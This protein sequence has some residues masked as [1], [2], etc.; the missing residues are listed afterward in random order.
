[1]AEGIRLT[2]PN[3]AMDETFRMKVEDELSVLLC[4]IRDNRLRL[5]RKWQ[6]FYRIFNLNLDEFSYAG[7]SK[8]Y[9]PALRQAGETVVTSMV[10][11]MFPTSDW[12]R[13]QQSPDIDPENFEDIL[14]SLLMH[15]FT[16]NMSLKEDAIPG[17]TQLVMYGSSPCK[18]AW[19]V[20]EQMMKVAE[21]EM[22]NG[23]PIKVIKDKMVHLYYGPVV[24]WIDL[25]NFYAW[26]E[27]ANNIG[28]AEIVF[29]DME[30]TTGHIKDMQRQFMDP[31]NPKLGPVYV[32]EDDMLISASDVGKS[33]RNFEARRQRLLRMG[34]T[35]DP[36]DRW[37][38][39]AVDRRNLTEVY[40]LKD[41]G[42]GKLPYLITIFNDRWAVRIQENPFY[43]KKPPYLF[44]RFKRVLNELY[45][46]S[47]Y[48]S[49]DRIQYMINDIANQTMDSIQY[50]LNP[51]TII[52]PSRVSYSQ[53]IKFAPGAKWLGDPA[54][55]QFSSPAHVATT[56]FNAI[57]MLSGLVHD[58]TASA[59]L[60]GIPA[61]R[62][63][64]RSQNTAGGM[65][66]SLSQAGGP[67]RMHVENFESEWGKP[68]LHM[69]YSRI[70]Q[71]MDTKI[72]LR[73]LGRKGAILEQRSVDVVDVVGNYD[74]KWL[75]T[76]ASR[77]RQVLSQQMINFLNIAGGLPPQILQSF[78]WQLLAKKIWT[79]GF[80][81]LESDDIFNPMGQP[82]TVDPKLELELLR[83][84]R[85]IQVSPVEDKM[86]H[87]RQ[88]AIDLENEK[89]DD[90]REKLDEHITATLDAIQQEAIQ[91]EQLQ[92][93][94]LMAQAQAGLQGGGDS[95]PS[96]QT[97][98][99]AGANGNAASDAFRQSQGG[100]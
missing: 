58:S 62:G 20:I 67:I 85:N 30:V 55:F 74:F 26:P 95:R 87:L 86:A 18:V 3:L 1:M 19:R 41:F 98:G 7:R 36:S 21:K 4:Q 83:Q 27:T 17:I 47:L 15:F 91:Q 54:G 68:L 53:S 29:Q 59:A 82:V 37:N 72:T 14:H 2:Y 57:N 76:I 56:G 81:L 96:P 9:I 66:Q 42:Q 61:V 40:W 92:Q 77:N 33:T 12:F 52:D 23:V 6:R 100:I 10:Q 99:S 50:E 31:K 94:M 5:E 39:L 45:G 64:G 48:E 11:D 80:G 35:S 65:A 25:F 63:Q 22:K 97:G 79:E 90:I 84:N 28:E 46:R 89:R 49:S 16:T 44:P 93:A 32:I 60:Q 24:Q 13:I 69:V 70:S 88:H 8:I 71:F 43:D 75:G 78:N 38:K 51:I 73:I 34:I